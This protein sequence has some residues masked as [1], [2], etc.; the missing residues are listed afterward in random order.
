M[1]GEEEEEEEGGGTHAVRRLRGCWSLV[2]KRRLGVGGGMGRLLGVG[3]RGRV[4]QV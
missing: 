2:S 4:D 3:S 1:G